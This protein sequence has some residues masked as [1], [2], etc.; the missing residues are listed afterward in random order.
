MGKN[1]GVEVSRTCSTRD[2]GVRRK[3]YSE[4]VRD[5]FANVSIDCNDS[6]KIYF[7]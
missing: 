6:I 4:K 5:Y 3:C 1:K 2:R 7:K